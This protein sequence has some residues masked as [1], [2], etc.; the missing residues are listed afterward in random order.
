MT[1]LDRFMAYAAAFEEAV[2]NDDW[3]PVG[4]FFTDDADYQTI[5]PPPFGQS[6]KGRAAVLAHFKSSLDGFDRLWDTREVSVLG[7][8]EVS[9][10]AVRFRW[11]ETLRKPGL[12]DLRLEGEELARFAGDRIQH[13][14]DR[15]T[16]ETAAEVQRYLGA[17]G[18]ALTRD[19]R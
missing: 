1:I 10:D 16:A 18:A 9:A 15:F 17:H 6:A 5:G 8:P 12:P 13:L 2:A 7:T 11:L 14:E 19:R 4:T 3:T